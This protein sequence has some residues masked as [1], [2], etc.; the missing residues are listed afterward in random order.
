VGAGSGRDERDQCVGVTVMAVGSS[1]FEGVLMTIVVIGAGSGMGA[2]VARQLA[3]RGSLL[4]VDQN[5]EGI[6]QIAAEIG[7]TGGDVKPVAC[8]VTDQGQVDDLAAEIEDL[9]VL[10][11]TAGLSGTMASG[12]RVLEVNLVGTAR[13]LSAVEPLL[14]PGSVAVCFASQ[15]GYMVPEDPKLFT[16]LEDPLSESFFDQLAA[17]FDVDNPAL[18]YQ[19]SKRG[20]HRLV[21]RKAASWGRLGARILSLSPGINDTPMNRRDEAAH[22]IMQEIIANSPLGR[23]GRQEEVANVVSFLTSEGASYMT[24]SDVLVDGGMVSVLPDAWN[25]QRR[26]S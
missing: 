11:H 22:P 23:R 19:V 17:L 15:S 2:A 5:V 16:V 13:V 25:A 10:V 24:G 8:D 12:R 1:S 20:V 26:S 9:E 21:R 14:R 7:E 18:A 6:R 3:P 4:L